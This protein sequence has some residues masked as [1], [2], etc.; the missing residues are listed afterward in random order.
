MKVMATFDGSAFSE[1]ILPLLSRLAQLPGAEFVLFS[2]AE[3]PHGVRDGEPRPPVIGVPA[4]TAPGVVIPQPEPPAVETKE[5]AVERCI[6][7]RREYL[8]GLASKLPGIP[9]DV[10]ADVSDDP[11]DAIIRAARRHSPDVIVMATHGLSGVAQALF[12][13]VAE[14]VVRSS[15][16]PVLLVHPEE[17]RRE[18]GNQR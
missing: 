11:A 8:L 9:C 5:Q 14:R 15:V 18:R 2:S 4:A 12:G 1:A 6:A 10:V 13:S 7:E 17:V 3:P 16:A